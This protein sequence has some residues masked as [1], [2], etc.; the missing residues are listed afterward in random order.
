[1]GNTSSRNTQSELYPQPPPSTANHE[2]TSL[3]GLPKDVLG[4]IIRQIDPVEIARIFTVSKLFWRICS[5]ILAATKEL[6]LHDMNI[7]EQMLSCYPENSK[8]EK[9]S[10][11]H[12]SFDYNLTN[13]KF[14]S[15]SLREIYVADVDIFRRPNHIYGLLRLHIIALPPSLEKCILHFEKG[16]YHLPITFQFSGCKHLTHFEI[17]SYPQHKMGNVRILF[18]ED[19]ISLKT[20]ICY[21]GTVDQIKFID[22]YKW[23]NNWYSKLEII[24]ISQHTYWPFLKHPHNGQSQLIPE[25]CPNCIEFFVF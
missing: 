23:P 21:G 19:L 5:D 8:L 24:R 25:K 15:F 18:A 12:C 14:S 16:G 17:I 2:L 22:T 20:F 3:F 4:L 10:L 9:L 11:T 1:M 6:H 13:L 7:T